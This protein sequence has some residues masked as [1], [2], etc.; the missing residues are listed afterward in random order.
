[1]D[2]VAAYNSRCVRLALGKPDDDDS[3]DDSPMSPALMLRYREWLEVMV[4]LPA[5]HSW[6]E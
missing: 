2:E 3:E 4:P 5:P 6:L 1:M